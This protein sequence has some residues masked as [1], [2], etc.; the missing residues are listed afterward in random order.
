MAKTS[1]CPI[2]RLLQ[3]TN[4]P[5]SLSDI[6][7]ALLIDETTAAMVLREYRHAGRAR[8]VGARWEI[9]AR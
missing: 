4:F 2:E 1:D 6:A 5:L 3:M 7:E 9:V 8:Q